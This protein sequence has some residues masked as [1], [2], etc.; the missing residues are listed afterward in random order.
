MNN[1]DVIKWV[2]ELCNE[3]YSGNLKELMSEI[4]EFEGR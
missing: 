3:Q 2:I 1:T 4:R